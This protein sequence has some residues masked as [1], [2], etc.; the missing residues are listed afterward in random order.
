MSP[1]NDQHQKDTFLS[2]S[3]YSNSACIDLKSKIAKIIL[4]AENWRRCTF[5]ESD[6]LP[7]HKRE[8]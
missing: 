3:H 2:I 5:F 8:V 6:R 7:V 1:W 4:V